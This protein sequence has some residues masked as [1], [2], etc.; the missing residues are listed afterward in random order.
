MGELQHNDLC[1]IFCHDYGT[2]RMICLLCQG[3]TGLYNNSR[4]GTDE[5]FETQIRGLDRRVCLINTGSPGCKF[6]SSD[7][8]R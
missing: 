2:R 4:S 6:S 5:I 8:D 3:L 1:I 7:G